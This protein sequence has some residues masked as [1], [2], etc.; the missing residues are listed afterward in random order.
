[1]RL[2][3]LVC[4]F[5]LSITVPVLTGC[6]G[7]AGATAASLESLAVT[8]ADAGVLIGASAQFVATGTFSDGTTAAIPNAVWTSSDTK[9]ATFNTTAGL[10]LGVAAGKATITATVAAVSGN[11]QFT[12]SSP[13]GAVRPQL[14]S[15]ADTC[16]LATTALDSCGFIWTAINLTPGDSY[17]VQ[18]R[19]NGAGA[20]T[21]LF[22]V[23]FTATA[24]TWDNSANPMDPTYFNGVN[25]CGIEGNNSCASLEG[26]A[27][28]ATLFFSDFG[29]SDQSLP[30]NWTWN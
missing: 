11:T 19:I 2:P 12:V 1:M 10:A 14:L 6:G 15:L 9:V 30:I 24:T 3:T 27:D 28:T 21:T 23:H 26:Q 8:P 22:N 18:D 17:I 5:S 4:L 7:S 13:A 29:V 25:E 16:N 20:G